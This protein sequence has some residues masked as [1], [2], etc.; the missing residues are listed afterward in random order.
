MH[1]SLFRELIYLLG[2]L[3][4]ILATT[5]HSEEIL[6]NMKIRM[7]ALVPQTSCESLAI[8]TLSDAISMVFCLK[9]AQ[10]KD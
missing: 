8:M 2:D 4:R 6:Q 1:A 3:S 9:W 5:R 7:Q 10:V